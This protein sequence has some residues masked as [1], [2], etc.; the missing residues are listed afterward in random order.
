MVTS[1][2]GA[3]ATAQASVSAEIY[4]KVD[5]IIAP[6]KSG[7]IRIVG[8]IASDQTKLSAFGQLRSALASFQSVAQALSGAGLTSTATSSSKGVLGATASASVVAGTHA[9]EVKQLA[10]NQTLASAA[11]ASASTPIGTGSVTTI[12]I[13]AGSAVDGKFSADGNASKTITIGSGNNTLQ[14][15]AD[16]LKQAGIDTAVVK[17]GDGFTLS[18]K[19]PAGAN[20][21][22]R[23][24]V[25]GDAAV[26]DLLAY[27]PVGSSKL[28]QTT[29][30]G[31]AILNVDGKE[32]RSASNTVSTAIEGVTL[33]L[34]AAGK[35]SVV[36][37][38]DPS[39]IAR[40]VTD[41]VTA[42]NS[43]N[44]K[45]A[46]LQK[47]E[48]KS[49]PA[50]QQISSQL[51]R[52]V[53]SGSFGSFGALGKA[54]VT[55]GAGGN[56]QIDNAQLTSAIAADPQAIGKLFTNNGNGIADQF[57]SKLASLTGDGGRL[58]KQEATVNKELAALGKKKADITAV[59]AKEATA[60]IKL[61]TDQQASASSSGGLFGSGNGKTAFDYFA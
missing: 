16:A 44:S 50:L 18:I 61:Y 3:A 57:A 6:Q 12:T 30:A 48:L 49:D 32:V 17:N 20:N 19:G 24:S 43:L 5:K 46:E 40:N 55:V 37:A 53:A 23:I 60:L 58:Q 35:T 8:N 10:T 39:Q 11:Q 22:L 2:Q 29:A 31:D 59:L 52:L 33:S 14:G 27:N 45:I 54:G 21:S 47:G 51:T 7:L 36:V 9:V 25:S 4:A 15:I 38:Q 26:K 41:L 28:T 13:D 56:L 42:Y 34:T 1:V